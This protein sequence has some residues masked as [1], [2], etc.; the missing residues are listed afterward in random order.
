M[1]DA[2]EHCLLLEYPSSG[3]AHLYQVTLLLAIP[4]VDLSTDF[5][6]PH[7]YLL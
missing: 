2:C 7:P 5:S 1:A 4:C 3:S 6:L